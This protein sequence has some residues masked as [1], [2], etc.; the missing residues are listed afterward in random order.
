MNHMN[1]TCPVLFDKRSFWKLATRSYAR[2][3]FNN[4]KPVWCS[5]T[6]C[7]NFRSLETSR[8]VAL[9]VG[10]STGLC[11]AVAVWRALPSVIALT[12]L[13]RAQETGRKWEKLRER[14]EDASTHHMQDVSPTEGNEK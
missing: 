14:G 2:R 13:E 8:G 11:V 6:H 7:S 12:S 3:G 5:R 4:F 9:C 1:N 10:L